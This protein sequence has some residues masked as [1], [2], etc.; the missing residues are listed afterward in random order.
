[1]RLTGT[2]IHSH[3]LFKRLK[4]VHYL[5][6]QFG[7]NDRADKNNSPVSKMEEYLG[8]MVDECRA[9]GAIPVLDNS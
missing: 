6:I 4:R 5:F 1:M 8:K 2:I 7:I 3:Q 9:K